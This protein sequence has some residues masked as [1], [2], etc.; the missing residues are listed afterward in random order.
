MSFRWNPITGKLDVIS[1]DSGSSSF[2]WTEETGT[3]VSM[4]VANGYIADNASLVTLTLPTT[5]SVGGIV[6]VAGKGSG[7]FAIAQNAGQTIYYISTNTT[8][9]AGGS[10][11]ANEQYDSIE[12]ICITAD[13]DWLVRSS[14]GS[15]TVV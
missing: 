3:N 2:T 15:F 12:L 5:A 13:T 14:T 7:K 1:N 10:I 6:A 11:T 4:N 8:T 9:G